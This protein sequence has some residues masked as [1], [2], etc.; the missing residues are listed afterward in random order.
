MRRTIEDDLPNEARFLRNFDQFRAGIEN[1]IDMPERT[2]NNLFVFLRQ[3]G[4]R[5]SRRAR[6]TEFAEL[7]EGEISRIE[8]LYGASFGGGGASRE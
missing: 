8:E 5:L 4:G 6:E 3:N 2:L 1:M 7:T